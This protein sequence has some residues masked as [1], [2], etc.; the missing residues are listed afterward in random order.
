MDTSLEIVKYLDMYLGIPS[1]VLDPDK[2]RRKLYG[3]AGAFRLQP[4]G[5]EYRVLSS[6]MMKDKK[7]LEFVW[8]GICAALNAYNEGYGRLDASIVTDIINNSKVAEAKETVIYQSLVNRE[9]LD[10]FK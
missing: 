8:S 4:W 5:V 6:G 9:Y 3:K 2:K 1:V 7:T 10:L